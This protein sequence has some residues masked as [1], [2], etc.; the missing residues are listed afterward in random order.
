MNEVVKYANELNKINFSTLTPNQQNILFTILTLMKDSEGNTAEYKLSHILELAQI[1]KRSNVDYI[2]DLF[3]KIKDLQAFVFRYKDEQKDEYYQETIFPKMVINPQK[4]SLKI[5]I[6]PEFKRMY[7]AVYKNF[8][9][10]QLAEFA[11][12]PSTYA[13]TIYRCLRQFHNAGYWDVAWSDFLEIL[14]IPQSYRA[15]DIDKQIL[16]PTLK[17]LAEP[18]LF[19][20]ERVPFYGLNFKKEK[21]GKKI[22]RIIFNFEPK[23]TLEQEQTKN[24]KKSIKAIQKAQQEQIA[25]LKEQLKKLENCY[26]NSWIS[27]NNNRFGCIQEIYLDENNNIRYKTAVYLNKPAL[28][29]SNFSEIINTRFDNLN[30]ISNFIK[31][32]LVKEF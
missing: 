24:L 2:H 27:F 7:L 29:N 15:R 16:H 26:K 18:G 11:E 13:K 19:D 17:F 1:D 12:I 28:I 10:F 4:D 22:E 30:D 8:T 21:K 31:Q 23:T 9:Y 5:T 14:G 3:D 25:E 32:R 6:A 20:P